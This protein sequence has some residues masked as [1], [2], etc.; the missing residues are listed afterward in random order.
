MKL[1]SR[2]L[3]LGLLSFSTTMALAALDN[4][5]AEAVG[6][7]ERQIQKIYA[8]QGVVCAQDFARV[9]PAKSLNISLFFGYGNFDEKTFDRAQ[10][11]AM[12]Y[13]LK[14]PCHGG[15]AVCGF[16][17]I[18]RQD[19]LTVLR[20][21]AGGREITVR[22]YSTSINNNGAAHLDPHGQYW[23]QEKQSARV[24]AEFYRDLNRSDA[25]FFLGHSRG[26]GGL[27][28]NTS[29]TAQV[30]F[31]LI[32]RV[33]LRPMLQALSQQPASLKMLGLFGCET[34]K[35]YRADVERVA[36]R[37]SLLVSKADLELEEGPQTM[38]GAL[39]ALLS[40]K[41]ASGF[42]RSLISADT[43]IANMI[44]VPR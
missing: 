26:G 12:A 11:F 23:D 38:L 29:T 1:F 3:C 16:R 14:R 34:E 4:D 40:R 27:G 32:F 44:Y 36:P 33:P 5:S 15:V 30:V 17:Q 6:S 8:E 13:T 18:S 7:L 2:L 35:Y 39:D 41:C 43:G 31:N 37:L 25:V 42:S 20:K 28:F 21:S 24:R 22:I 19:H 9:F 10:S